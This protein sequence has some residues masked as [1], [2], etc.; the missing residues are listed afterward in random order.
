MIKD[1]NKVLLDQKLSKNLI[2]SSTDPKY[3]QQINALADENN[4]IPIC[5]LPFGAQKDLE[6]EGL[7]LLPT[8]SKLT[9]EDKGLIF[10]KR[11][12]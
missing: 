8:I 1:N 3:Y 6:N 12:L 10:N 11:D 5:E 9:N 7:A 2:K 4:E